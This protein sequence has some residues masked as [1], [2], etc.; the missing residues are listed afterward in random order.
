MKKADAKARLT[1]AES[2]RRRAEEQAAHHCQMVRE[3]V[4]ASGMNGVKMGELAARLSFSETTV[5]KYL[6]RMRADGIVERTHEGGQSCR[7][8][9]PGIYAAFAGERER[10]RQ[11]TRERNRKR[12]LAQADASAAEEWAE[13][14]AL[15]VIVRACDAPP[16]RPAGPAS[17]WGLAA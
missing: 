15:R 1:V 8:G 4:L 14:P 16:L 17:V 7:W 9:S 6:M 3:L 11:A 13:R 12:R 5:R 2:N 10:A